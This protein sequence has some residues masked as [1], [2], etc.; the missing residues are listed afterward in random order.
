VVKD[1]LLLLSE[2]LEL[3][4]ASMEQ[5]FNFDYGANK[6][7]VGPANIWVEGTELQVSKDQGISSKVCDIKAFSVFLC[8]MR[9]KVKVVGNL[10]GFVKSSIN[11]L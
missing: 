4:V 1:A 11:V 6:F 10:S 8:F 5:G 7:A 3:G 2:F 9:Y